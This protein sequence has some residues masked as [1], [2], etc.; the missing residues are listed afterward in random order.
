[1]K[2]LIVHNEYGIF[3][4]EEAV[5]YDVS[6]LLRERGHAV[7]MFTRSSTEIPKM[8]LGRIR[9]FFSGIYSHS[10]VREFTKIITQEKPDIVQIQ[11]VYPFISPA[12]FKISRRAGVPVVFRCANYRLFCPYGPLHSGGE[13][14][15]R[16]VGGKEYWCVLRNCMRS[17]PKS[18]GY[19]LRNAY[20]RI[21]GGIT[22]NTTMYYVPS[23]FQK[24]KFITWGIPAD[25]IAVIPNFINRTERFGRAD[26]LGD[27]VGYAGRISPEKGLP[28]LLGAAWKCRDIPFRI[29]GGL[30]LM[31]EIA[32]SA[33]PNVS[34]LGR[35]TPDDMPKFYANARM[36]VVPSIWYETFGMVIIEGMVERRPVIA[37]KIGPIPTVVDDNVTG[38][39]FEPGNAKDLAEKIR[40]LWDRPRLCQQMGQA[41]CEKALREYSPEKYY[42]RLMAVYE[43]AIKLG[44]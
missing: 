2:I 36:L 19:A 14:C 10:S 4:G 44:P 3:T 39:L 7:T 25:R 41:G 31:P 8:R 11:N 35:L 21:S 29:A 23:E 24:R 5:V 38:L 22:K 33:P 32:A 18:I 30:E 17:I 28:S 37:S 40:Y 1:M 12:V 15:E 20:A 26:K 13:V 42:E 16:C 27:Y 43:K 9:A 34:F 6:K